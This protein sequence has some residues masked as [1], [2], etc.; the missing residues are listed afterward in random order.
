MLQGVHK[1]LTEADAVATFNGAKFDLPKLNGQFAITGMLPPPPPTQIDIFLA[2]RK[3]GFICS[4]LDYVAPI[5]GLG[6]KV[7]HP[8]LEMWIDAKNGC[9]KAQRKMI[10]Y[11]AGDVRLTE[12]LYNAV[13]PFIANHPHMGVTPALACGACG[14]HQVT[15][16][17]VRRTKA[18][19]S[20]AP[21]SALRIV[22]DGQAGE[23]M[24][25]LVIFQYVLKDW[26]DN[27]GQKGQGRVLCVGHF[28][29]LYAR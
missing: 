3:M 24:I 12:D 9:P 10:T 6:H 4:K 1:A 11:C 28:F 5:F 19:H 2:V 8:G 27:V 13:R 29:L 26:R 7:K 15:S 25:A 16:Q 18:L 22:A 21:V 20:A 17:G 23:R 14:S